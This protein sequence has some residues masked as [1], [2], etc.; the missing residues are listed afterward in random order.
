[1]NN[2]EFNR[3][4]R[5]EFGRNKENE[6]GQLIKYSSGRR[7]LIVMGQ[8]SAQKTGL[9]EKI[10]RSLDRSGLEFKELTGVR[11][12][13]L[14]DKARLGVK[15]CRDHSID[16]VLALGG[17]SVI[18][19]AKAIAAGV[20]YEGDVWDIFTKRR[21]LYRA[22]PVGVVLTNPGSGSECSA[23]AVLSELH[24][25]V[26][27]KIDA[28]YECFV[29]VFAILNPELTFSLDRRLT[30]LGCADM[31]S[32]VLECYFTN[33]SGVDLTDRLAEGLLQSIIKQSVELVRDP[34]S[35]D[36]RA[37]L[38]WAGTMAHNDFL[39]VG[40]EQDWASHKLEYQLSALY[41]TPHGAGLAVILP[42]W[43]TFVTHHNVMRMAQFS[44]RVMG[45]PLNFQ[46]PLSTAKR[47]IAKLR[48][49]FSTLGL[50][51]NFAELGANPA[52]IERMLD[53]LP[54]DT[55]GTL[56]AYVKLNR[57]A[58]EAIYYL[59]ATYVPPH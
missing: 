25:G 4:T 15:I 51:Q 46:D 40:R 8:Q 19:T 26:R 42:A 3:R 59:A 24:Q 28:S 50:P 38:M 13:P 49:F 5:L 6:V 16:F 54:Y 23:N 29:P 47:G 10:K 45:V 43:M 53:N 37:N 32:H 17:G 56:G 30:A 39:G 35:Y 12:N 41:D 20:F 9:I 11:A 52:D 48:S 31:L 34:S 55:D 2:F 21:N 44:T 1:M 57:S 22:L 58:C 14:I 36:A 7:V 18:D 27:H 33:T